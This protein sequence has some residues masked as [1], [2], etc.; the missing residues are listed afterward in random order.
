MAVFILLWVLTL[1]T[2]HYECRIRLNSRFLIK[3]QCQGKDL[4]CAC[5]AFVERK[6]IWWQGKK[7]APSFFHLPRVNNI[8]VSP[9]PSIQEPLSRLCKYYLPPLTLSQVVL[10]LGALFWIYFLYCSLGYLV[11]KAVSC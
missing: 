5:F 2:A 9:A 6:N 7:N 3:M 10:H 8:S 4:E 11:A 1:G